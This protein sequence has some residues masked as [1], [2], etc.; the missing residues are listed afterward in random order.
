MTST[1]ARYRHFSDHDAT[2]VSAVYADWARGISEHDG[3]LDL[4]DSLPADKRHPTLVFASARW[5]GCPVGPWATTREWMLAHWADIEPV[6]LSRATQTNE[7]GR[8]A[9]LLGELA[10][11]EGS[12]ALLEVGASAGLCLYPDRYSYRYS[13]HGEQIALDPA[14]GASSV[15]LSCDLI[16]DTPPPTRLPEVVWRAGIDR[17]PIYLADDEQIRWLDTLVWPGQEPRRSRLR[18]AAALVSADPPLLVRGDLVDDLSRIAALA[19]GDATLVVFH[20]AVLMY[21]EWERR[22]L[23]VEAVTALDAVWLSNE[24]AEIVPQI[25]ERLPAGLDTRGRFVLA[26]DGIPVALTGPHGQSLERITDP[27]RRESAA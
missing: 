14:D 18:A 23:F 3:L 4:I 13:R 8:C 11:I 20:S 24:S 16:G 25:T 17:S 2:P 7:A 12:V 6:I 19:P 21:P 1:A 22:E 27:V 10:S 5:A 26:R 9:T 15:I